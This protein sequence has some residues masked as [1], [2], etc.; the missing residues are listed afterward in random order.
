M[1]G[2]HINRARPNKCIDTI[3]DKDYNKIV[4]KPVNNRPGFDINYLR[5]YVINYNSYYANQF[6]KVLE[7]EKRYDNLSVIRSHETPQQWAIRVRQAL[8]KI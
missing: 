4:P 5:A 1:S 8:I 6:E 3:L 2:T 7:V